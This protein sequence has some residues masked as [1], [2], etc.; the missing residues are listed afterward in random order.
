VG[1]G[2][3]ST[4]ENYKD[5]IQLVTLIGA[6][7]CGYASSASECS[8]DGEGATTLID[9]PVQG[10]DVRLPVR[11]DRPLKRIV[12]SEECVWEWDR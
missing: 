11:G 2:V 12:C 1:Q 4:G 5:G 3:G 7:T 6:L 8:P 9:V 10:Y